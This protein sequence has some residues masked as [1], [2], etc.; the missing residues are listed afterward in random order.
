M[1]LISLILP[2]IG[3]FLQTYTRVFNKSFGVDVWT[4]LLEADHV[5]KNNHK[6]PN[7]IG[8]QFIIEGY[9]DYPPLFPYLL[10][11]INKRTIEKYQGLVAPFFDAIN[12]FLLFYVAY[13]FTQD[14][15][16]ALFSQLIYTLSPIVV[17][18]NSSLTPRSFGYLNFNLAF[19]SSLVYVINGGYVYLAASILF[20]TLIFLSHRFAMQSLMFIS[21]F[22]SIYLNTPYFA[23]VFIIGFLCATLVTGGYYIRVLI[24]HLWNIYFW[25]PN[26]VYRFS[27]Q[28]RGLQESG[29]TKD[30]VEFVYTMLSKFAPFSLVGTNIWIIVPI[31]VATSSLMHINLNVPGYINVLSVWVVFFYLLGI[32]IL[33]LTI[34]RC[35]GEGYRYL[36]MATIPTSIVA[37]WSFFNIRNN[38]FSVHI[39]LMYLLIF[40]FNICLIFFVHIKIIKDRNRSVTKDM[41]RVFNFLNK[42]KKIYRILCIPHQNTTNLIYHTKHQ[43]FVNADNSG[44]MTVS[45]V[46]PVIKWPLSETIKK[47]DLNLVF[48]KESFAKKEELRLKNMR[49]IFR[50]GDIVLLKV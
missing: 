11:F 10:S 49:E 9:F 20:T 23:V 6:I 16:I 44:L 5:R 36:E 25:I 2:I 12:N 1:L 45:C 26:R 28:V 40:L 18:E 13:F 7:K 42:Q 17:L 24:G 8:G 39:S 27:H 29:K 31:I 37:A 32:P 14:L 46:Y 35:I 3:F 22:F 21:V 50:S 34:F 38:E 41:D 48:L 30:F 19:I 4:R 43:I 33:L 47:Y 15:N